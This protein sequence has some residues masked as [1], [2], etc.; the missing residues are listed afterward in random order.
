M[1]IKCQFHSRDAIP[2]GATTP[3]NLMCLHVDDQAIVS[4]DERQLEGL[5]FHLVS[6]FKKISD[7]GAVNSFLGMNIS[8][9]E[10][11]H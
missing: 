6:K 4:N 9:N 5:T 10:S 1:A 2:V 11:T 8:Y 7:L 3:V